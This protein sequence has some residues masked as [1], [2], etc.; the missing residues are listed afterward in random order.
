MADPSASSPVYPQSN[1]NVPALAWALAC[2]QSQQWADEQR[3]LAHRRYKRQLWL[4][5][6]SAVFF[7]GS[8]ATAVLTLTHKL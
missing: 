6:A 5:G 1:G 8:A 3:R 7:V 4:L 2:V